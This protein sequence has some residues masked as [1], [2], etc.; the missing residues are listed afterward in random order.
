MNPQ[1]GIQ[2]RLSG[3]EDF[4]ALV[5]LQIYCNELSGAAAGCGGATV[6]KAVGFFFLDILNLNHVS[7]NVAHK[8]TSKAIYILSIPLVCFMT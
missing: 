5:V 7:R 2:W 4:T 8:C 1:L 3:M 6:T